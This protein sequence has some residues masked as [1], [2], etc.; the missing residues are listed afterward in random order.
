M[1]TIKNRGLPGTVK[2]VRSGNLRMLEV[3]PRR[4][5]VH[6]PPQHRVVQAYKRGE[7]YHISV[8]MEWELDQAP[9]SARLREALAR[10]QKPH[11][12]R[13]HE[14]R[15]E[16]ARDLREGADAHVAHPY[17]L[18]FRRRQPVVELR[19]DWVVVR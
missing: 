18:V 3:T 17:V 7:Q 2:Y 9:D 11:E 16:G 10:R 8:I 6:L 4:G 12:E 5:W 15:V 19:Y 14:R 1:G 13:Q